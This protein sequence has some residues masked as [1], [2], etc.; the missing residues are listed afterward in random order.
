MMYLLMFMLYRDNML[1]IRVS[2]FMKFSVVY[3]VFENIY[4]FLKMVKI[5]IGMFIMDIIKFV[6]VRVSRKEFVI[7]FR[8]LFWMIIIYI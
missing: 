6:V 8:F 3:V 7:V 2:I 1:V 4:W 5:V